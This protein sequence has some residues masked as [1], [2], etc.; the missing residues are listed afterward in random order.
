M[1]TLYATYGIKHNEDASQIKFYSLGGLG[2]LGK[3][4][5]LGKNFLILGRFFFQAKFNK[6][7]AKID[8]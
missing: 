7:W 8:N 1:I 2:L 6:I 3:F 5:N 4:L